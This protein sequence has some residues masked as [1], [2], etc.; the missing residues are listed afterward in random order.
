MSDVETAPARSSWTRWIPLVLIGAG[1]AAVIASGAYKYLSLDTL[2]ANRE[3]LRTFVAD[4]LL[5]AAAAYVGLY[6]LVTM[7]AIPGSLWVTITGGF[8]FGV[9]GGAALTW[10]AA[11]VGATTLFLAARGALA[12]ILERQ[13]TGWLARLRDG[14]RKNAFNYLLFLRLMP[15]APFPVVNIAPAILGVPTR[16]FVLATAIGIVPGTFVYT[17][18]GAGV[19][20]VLDQGGEPDLSLATKPMIWGP[21]V[22]FGLLALAP[23]IYQAWSRRKRGAAG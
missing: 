17:F 20:A 12:S 21:L 15:L 4:H 13:A 9:A 23:V 16:T 11:M 1:L 6:L 2:K 18:L 14:F 22:A 7:M 19:G 10:F 3:V 5:L 8:L